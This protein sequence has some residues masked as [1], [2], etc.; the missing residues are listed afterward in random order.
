MNKRVCHIVG[1]G[2][3]YSL[4]LSPGEGDLVIAADAGLRY[5]QELGVEPDLVIGDFDTL[6]YCPPGDRVIRLNPEKDDTDMLAAVREGLKRGYRRFHLRCAM[7]GKIEHSLA[8]IQLLSF[9]ADNGA[10]GFLFDGSAILTAFCADRLCFPAGCTGRISVLSMSD[11]STGVY[12]RGLRYALDD[13][14]LSN[15]FPLGVSNEFTGKESSVSVETGTLLA[16]YP[17]D[18]GAV[19][20]TKLT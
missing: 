5:L 11:R 17:R 1:A 13:A 20:V 4:A 10:Q 2:E 14:T 8:N 16:I 15:S 9:L 19:Y 3:N 6:G 12:E 18:L 7:G